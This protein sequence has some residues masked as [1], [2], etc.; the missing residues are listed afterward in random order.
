MS[1]YL[2]TKHGYSL[3]ELLLVVALILL[4]G[5]STTPFL[6]NF[7]QR[8]HMETTKS[9]LVSFL[10]KAQANTMDGKLN[11]DW[12]V[13]LSGDTLLLYADDCSSPVQSFSHQIPGSIGITGFSDIQFSSVKGVPSATPT[14]TVT[15]DIDVQT[16]TIN[17]VGMVNP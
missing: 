1:I 16:I 10:R 9:S 14:I 6:S 2:Q 11:V 17:A 12:G 15:S 5:A 4:L 8:N 3:I 13:C 7:I